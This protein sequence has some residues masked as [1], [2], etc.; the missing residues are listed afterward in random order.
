MTE[1]KRL[2]PDKRARICE[3]WALIVPPPEGKTNKE[4]R[5]YY[6][7]KLRDSGDTMSDV[8]YAA[9]CRAWN[10]FSHK[11]KYSRESMEDSGQ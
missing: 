3:N 7:A 2:T 9:T 10:I 1:H 4:L 8:E 6:F 5:D 11:A